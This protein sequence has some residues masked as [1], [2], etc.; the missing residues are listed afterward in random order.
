M[1]SA[2]ALGITSAGLGLYQ[3]Y[4]QGEA[5]KAQAEA[6]ADAMERNAE[7]AR[8]QGHDAIERGGIEEL[9][10]RRNIAQ[11][12]G[13]QRA[14]LATNEV[15]INS[16]SAVDVR[17]ASIAAGEYDAE[18]IRFNAARARWGYENQADNLEIQAANTRAAGK[19]AA[20]NALFGGIAQAG[21]TGADLY[22]NYQNSKSS[23]L[24]DYR[25]SDWR[26]TTYLTNQYYK[27]KGK[28]K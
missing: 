6:Q 5:A 2:I 3:G 1:C 15:D 25:P 19:A 24:I 9:K 14:S 11:H 16:G 8:A 12:L 18:A 21:L 13:N 7:F 22:Y 26:R 28:S 23:P 10:L 27:N 17:N 4:A 20:R